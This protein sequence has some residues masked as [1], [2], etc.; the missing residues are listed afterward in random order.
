MLL[1]STTEATSDG[2]FRQLRGAVMLNIRISFTVNLKKVFAT[3][4]AGLICVAHLV[5]PAYALTVKPVLTKEKVV[6][7]NLTYLTVSTTKS[8]AQ[9]AL[10]SPYVKYFDPQT[11]AFLTT[12]AKG[13]SLA[14]WKALNSLWGQECHFNPKAVNM[15][16]YAYGIAQFLPSTWSNYKV[17]KTSSA[18]L[19]I[20]Y[21][22]RY[23][24]AR[25]GGI[26]DTAGI[27]NAWHHEQTYGWY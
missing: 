25:Y 9:A 10:K 2:G 18:S 4:A 16:S 1:L 14:E 3:A 22:L 7:V 12:Y 27:F 6:T 20:K 5:T 24:Q 17:V 15:S 8:Q 21:G 13:L 19:Q 26:N 11:I 23:I